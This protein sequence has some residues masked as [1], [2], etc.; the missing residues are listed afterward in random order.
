MQKD[1]IKYLQ[2][3][4]A[5]ATGIIASIVTRFLH[6]YK[7]CI[8]LNESDD[9]IKISVRGMKSLIACGLDLAEVLMVAAE[10]AGDSG[11]GHSIASGAVIPKANDAADTFLAT[12]DSMVGEQLRGN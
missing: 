3:H 11:G 7:S 9:R 2:L 12:A 5:E 4:D 8:V 10:A 6:P 1:H